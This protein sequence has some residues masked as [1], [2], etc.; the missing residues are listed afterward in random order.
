MIYFVV[1]F[2]NCDVTKL[3]ILDIFSPRELVLRRKL[4]WVKHCTSNDKALK[5]SEYVEAH[6][7]PD[8]TNTTRSRIYP[9]IYLGPITNIQGTKKVFD[10]VTGVVE[11]PRSVTPFP[12]PDRVINIVNAWGRRYQKEEQLNKM[13]FLNNKKLK[14]DWDNDELNETDVLPSNSVHEGR[15]A[16]FP[17][18]EL[19]NEIKVPGSAVT[20]LSES[21]EQDVHGAAENTGYTNTPTNEAPSSVD[22]IVVIDL[23]SDDNKDVVLV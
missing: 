1:T 5:F 15:P 21:A 9:S 6:K 23:T 16:Q 19:E 7:D 11:K 3:G 4:D 12:M 13:E 18:I 17:G 22:N 14:F 20:I 2:L 8:V 10:L